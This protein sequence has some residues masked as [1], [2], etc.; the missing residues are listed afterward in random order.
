MAFL[1]WRDARAFLGCPFPHANGVFSSV[2]AIETDYTCPF[3]LA[4][5]MMFPVDSLINVKKKKNYPAIVDGERSF[6]G[7]FWSV[8]FEESMGRSELEAS[9]VLSL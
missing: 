6:A 5:T 4:H 1:L 3:L 7:E 2:A 8:C 9:S